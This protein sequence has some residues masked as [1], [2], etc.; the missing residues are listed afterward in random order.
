MFKGLTR[1]L[2]L[3][4]GIIVAVPYLIVLAVE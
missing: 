1:S 4:V 2:T 3:I